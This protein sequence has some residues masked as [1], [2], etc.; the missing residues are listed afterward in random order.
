MPRAVR[1]Y[2][3]NGFHNEAQEEAREASLVKA[4][5]VVDLLE[6]ACCGLWNSPLVAPLLDLC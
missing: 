1:A 2:L 3:K 6:N 5:L 4:Y